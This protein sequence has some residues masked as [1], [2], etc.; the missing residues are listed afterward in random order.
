MKQIVSNW[1][2]IY[3]ENGSGQST[4]VGLSINKKAGQ[5]WAYNF[6]EY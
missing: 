6:F 2:S 5:S 4:G 3:Y 1:T